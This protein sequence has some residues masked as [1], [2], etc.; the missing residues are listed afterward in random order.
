MTGN[1]YKSKR[2]AEREYSFDDIVKNTDYAEGYFAKD[3]ELTASPS[4][5]KTG[6]LKNGLKCIKIYDAGFPVYYCS[7]GKLYAK[8][9]EEYKSFGIPAT[10]APPALFSAVYDGKKTVVAVCSF[11]AYLLNDRISFVEIPKGSAYYEYKGVLFIAK[12][13]KIIVCDET[14]YT[15]DAFN[16]KTQNFL[17]PEA[18]FGTVEKFVSVSGSL[19]AICKRGA[20]RITLTGDPAEYEL[21]DCGLPAFKCIS[22][23]IAETG[24]EAYLLTREGL[25]KFNG[26]SLEKTPSFF[27]RKKIEPCGE[28]SAK[29]NY[30]LLPVNVDGNRKI[31]CREVISGKESFI[32]GEGIV[33]SGGKTASFIT[34]DTGETDFTESKRVW[35]SVKTDFGYGGLKTLYEIS[36]ESDTA[37]AVSVNGDGIERTFTVKAGEG[38][39]PLSVRAERFVITVTDFSGSVENRIRDL[40]VKY[41]I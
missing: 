3:G 18:R 7:D 22:E 23:S 38:K 11:G 12:G 10:N 40:K 26:K 28:A 33:I 27:D 16:V 15:G 25:F 41:R 37:V 14:E 4:V 5:K 6:K 39:V 31:Y 35:K 32:E 21:K 34:G 8:E 36:F 19:Y 20:I 29:D 9:G 17:L 24:N 2:T 1:L 13:R 30:Y